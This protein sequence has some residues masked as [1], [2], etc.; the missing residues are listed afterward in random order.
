MGK[1]DKKSW[2]HAQGACV[3]YSDVDIREWRETRQPA[4]RNG[5]RRAPF[6]FPSMEGETLV[7][8]SHLDDPRVVDSWQMDEIISSPFE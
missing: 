7:K 2:K 6:S 5:T 1:G 3:E 4:G 8:S